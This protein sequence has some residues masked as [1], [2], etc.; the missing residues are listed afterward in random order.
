MSYNKRF[1][2]LDDYRKLCEK[3]KCYID[4]PY[5]KTMYIMEFQHKIDYNFENTLKKL[6][7]DL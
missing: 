4:I 2:F 1:L 5:G 3:H 6:E 7:G